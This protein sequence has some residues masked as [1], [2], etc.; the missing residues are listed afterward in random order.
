MTESMC[1][2]AWALW[3]VSPSPG[4]RNAICLI[5]ARIRINN[6]EDDDTWH[7]TGHLIWCLLLIAATSCVV[8][9][10][11]FIQ[12]T[13]MKR[14][15]TPTGYP[16]ILND[17]QQGWY[18]DRG[19][20]PWLTNNASNITNSMLTDNSESEFDPHL[21]GISPVWCWSHVSRFSSRIEKTQFWYSEWPFELGEWCQ[22]RLRPGHWSSA[23]LMTAPQWRR[24]H[25][26]L[27]SY[28]S[29]P[30]VIMESPPPH[31]WPQEYDDATLLPHLF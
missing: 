5:S 3:A 9:Q 21:H 6:N 10:R 15:R 17:K 16:P 7:N 18:H 4:L 26:G 14:S 13:V 29:P 27:I 11:D 23:L 24:R 25:N 28:T 8:R 20:P 31:L 12:Q 2:A 19:G 1:G 22:L 30:L